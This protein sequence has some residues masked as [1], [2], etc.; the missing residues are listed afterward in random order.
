[1][2][3]PKHIG[4]YLLSYIPII[5]EIKKKD[6]FMSII[7]NITKSFNILKDKKITLLNVSETLYEDNIIKITGKAN[8]GAKIIS[9]EK[10]IE[11]IKF[12][13]KEIVNQK[14]K[15][16]DK[17][18]EIKK[19]LNNYKK[20]PEIESYKKDIFNFNKIIGD[21]IINGKLYIFINEN[22]DEIKLIFEINDT[23]QKAQILGVLELSIKFKE[24][25]LEAIKNYSVYISKKI[26][27]E[28]EKSVDEK[29][30]DEKIVLCLYFLVMISIDFLIVGEE[31]VSL[32]LSWL[33]SI[34]K[35]EAFELKNYAYFINQ[36]H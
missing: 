20:N 10:P 24:R 11:T 7:N 15:F 8:L 30:V 34:E 29:S 35:N 5:N 19:K 14:N 18:M 12:E 31:G 27:I 17:I 32:F 3:F 36:Y 4:N 22:R 6:D 28:E 2:F 16:F 21:N 25:G 13:D 9:D 23:Y 1:L 33:E 26:T